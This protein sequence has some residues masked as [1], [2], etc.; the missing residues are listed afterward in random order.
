MFQMNKYVVCKSLDEAYELLQKSKKNN[1]VAGC[2]FLK[3]GH[4]HI[5]QGLCVDHLIKNTIE[6]SDSFV[7]IGGTSTYGMLED[8][9]FLRQFAD[10]VIPKTLAHIV[11]RQLRNTAQVGAS[12]YSRYAFSDLLP[13]LLAL[14]AR[15]VL[16]HHGEMT[17]EEFF[18]LPRQQR[19]ILLE[20]KLPNQNGT[21]RYL[22]QRKATKD[23][24]LLNI[25]YVKTDNEIRIAV[26][27][28]PSHAILLKETARLVYEGVDFEN[29]AQCLVKEANCGTNSR[30]S[31]AYRELLIKGMIQKIGRSL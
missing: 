21:A 4:K 1:I 7:T 28:R 26:G 3:A 12:V 30:A 10:G 6:V 14:D 20:V 31:K 29:V 23:I 17:L 25:A 2:H 13:V 11:S 5:N 15:V 27:A 19:D 22:A 16:F 24:P 8:S 18:L 9:P